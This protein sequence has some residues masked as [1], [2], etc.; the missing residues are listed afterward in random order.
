MPR[1]RRRCFPGS[2]QRIRGDQRE[3]ATLHRIEQSQVLWFRLQSTGWES[4]GQ[5]PLGIEGFAAVCDN[6]EC[7]GLRCSTT[8]ACIGTPDQNS[9]RLFLVVRGFDIRIRGHDRGRDNHA[10]KGKSDQKVMHGGS[11]GAA[12]NFPQ[13]AVELILD[14]VSASF[15]IRSPSS[16]SCQTAEILCRLPINESSAG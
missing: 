10:N 15:S 8:A 4:E 9:L 11:P 7:R 5:F 14:C 12:Q 2:V 16:K 6:S 13:S 1:N 3:A